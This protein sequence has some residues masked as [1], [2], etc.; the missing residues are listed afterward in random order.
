MHFELT[1]AGLAQLREWNVQGCGV[2]TATKRGGR[3][4]KRDCV[5][6]EVVKMAAREGRDG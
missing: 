2:H 4:L 5:A 3:Q 6:P 1:P